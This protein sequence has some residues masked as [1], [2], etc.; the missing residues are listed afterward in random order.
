MIE[1]YN[2]FILSQEKMEN[3][4]YPN[5][6]KK[7]YDSYKRTTLNDKSNTILNKIFALDCEMV[8]I[9]LKILKFFILGK[10]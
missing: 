1:K 6:T 5:E 9:I 3:N 10:N 2:F 8:I 7:I 4:L